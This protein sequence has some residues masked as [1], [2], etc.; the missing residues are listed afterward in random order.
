MSERLAGN[1]T[2]RNKYNLNEL[3]G[4]FGDLGTLVPF[5]LIY[6]NVLHYEPIGLFF[7]FGI[8]NILTGLFYRTPIPVQPMKG[9]ATFAATHAGQISQGMISGAG[10]F[11]GFFWI[12]LAVTGTAEYIVKA[13]DKHVVKGILIGLGLSF[14]SQGAKMAVEGPIVAGITVAIFL[15]L[16]N[17]KRVPAMLVILLF[18]IISTFVMNPKT[19]KVIGTIRPEL[20]LPHVGF[21]LFTF[22][23]FLTGILILALPQ[24]PITMGMDCSAW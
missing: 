21:R 16:K 12:I 14:I 15:L 8:L 5:I 2:Q 10:I 1:A 11:S 7:T 9:I 22:N 17:N 18:G 23:E 20:T 3:A 13:I 4:A 24:I 6:I 19:I